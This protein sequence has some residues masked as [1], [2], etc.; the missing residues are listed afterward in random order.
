MTPAQATTIVQTL[1]N[2]DPAAT[3]ELVGI[4]LADSKMAI[5]R[6]LYPFGIPN[7]VSAVPEIYEMLW[8]KLAMRYFLRRGGE[9]ELVDGLALH[10]V[11]G[12]GYPAFHFAEADVHFAV[13]GIGQ[14]VDFRLDEV[15]LDA[16]E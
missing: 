1:L 16:V 7:D 8:C 2:N 13:V 10:V 9:G 5:L 6:R 14:N 15:V 4:Y 11:D 12:G 3:S